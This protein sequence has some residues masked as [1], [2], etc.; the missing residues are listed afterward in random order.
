ME[1]EG[2][3]EGG[4]GGKEGGRGGSEG[5]G[6]ERERGRKGGGKKAEQELSSEKKDYKTH[7]KLTILSASFITPDLI[8]RSNFES[9][10]K[11]GALFTCKFETQ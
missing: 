8:C 10:A 5:E 7:C 11:L 3:R 6:G 4:E 1:D 2:E 9:V